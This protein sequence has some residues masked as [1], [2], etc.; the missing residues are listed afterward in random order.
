MTLDAFFQE[1][2]EAPRDPL[3]EDLVAMVR[4][5]YA[6]TPRHQQVELGPSDVSHPCMRRMAMAM[7]Q[8]PR[9]NPEYDPLPSILGTA[10]H[11]WMESA[12][13]L[14]NE[15]LGRERWLIE[16]RLEVAAGLS[17]SCDLYDTDTDTVI[18]HKFLG[19]T[20]FTAYVKDI[21]PQY[22]SQVMLYG[23]GFRRLGRNVRRVAVAIFP[24]S[25]TLTNAHLWSADYDDNHAARVLT[26]REQAICLL[27]DLQVEIYPER[28]QWIPATPYSC[29]WC[30]FWRPEP[31]GPLQCRGGQ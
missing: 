9:C 28:Y 10:A 14:D 19:Y 3:R 22:K 23:R 20:S 13:R 21:G 25:G 6:A 8:V 27:D 5:R 17:G 30:P 2:I 26:R 18:D 24:R 16:T 29:I 15:R 1:A 11:T 12:A 7:M 31:D 4:Q